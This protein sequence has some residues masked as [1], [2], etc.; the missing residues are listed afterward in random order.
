MVQVDYYY[1]YY[2]FYYI[3]IILFLLLLLTSFGLCIDEKI[4]YVFVECPVR[5]ASEEAVEEAI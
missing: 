1:Y 3:I 5:Q 4:I 2:Y